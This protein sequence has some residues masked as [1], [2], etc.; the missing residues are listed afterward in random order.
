MSNFIIQLTVTV[1]Q[2]HTVERTVAF[3]L[4]QWSRERAA[5]LHYTYVA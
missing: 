1:A 2:H 3:P 4:Q 5:M